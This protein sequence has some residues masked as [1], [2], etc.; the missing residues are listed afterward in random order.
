MAKRDSV[1]LNK[2]AVFDKIGIRNI[3]KKY[4][5]YNIRRG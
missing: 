3:C 2:Y 5:F 1:F 4:I